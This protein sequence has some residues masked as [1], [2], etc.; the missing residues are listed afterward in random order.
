MHYEPEN[1]QVFIRALVPDGTT[2]QPTNH[3]PY[4]DDGPIAA[5][6]PLPVHPQQLG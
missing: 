5:L 4:H 2:N 3:Q 1:W 6:N